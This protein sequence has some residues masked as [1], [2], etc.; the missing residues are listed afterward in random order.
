MEIESSLKEKGLQKNSRVREGLKNKGKLKEGGQMEGI[1]SHCFSMFPMLLRASEG[2][3][4]RCLNLQTISQ[5]CLGVEKGVRGTGVA[6]RIIFWLY[7]R[8]WRDPLRIKVPRRG[9]DHDENSSK[10]VCEQSQLLIN[11]RSTKMVLVVWDEVCERKWK[12][13]G[14]RGGALNR[15]KDG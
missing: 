4:W 12:S 5:K 6:R 15:D 11:P 1:S 8:S 3:S 13:E 2:P 7:E 10:R 14:E 9:W